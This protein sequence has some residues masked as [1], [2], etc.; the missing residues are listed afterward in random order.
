MVSPLSAYID[1]DIMTREFPR[2]EVEPVVWHLNLVA[3]DDFLL[4]DTISI[5]QAVAPGGVVEGSETVKEAG[6]KPAK[7]AI[8]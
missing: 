5:S 1:I 2:V 7:T 4:E 6:S 3:I 8:A